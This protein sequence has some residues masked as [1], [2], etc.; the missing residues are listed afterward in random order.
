MLLGDKADYDCK[1][2]GTFDKGADNDGRH[3]VMAGLLRLAG[4]SLEGSL[5]DLTDTE[6]SGKGSQSRTDGLSECPQGQS[7]L[8]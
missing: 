2:T 4:S 6:C 5:S 1:Q 7:C 3:P 8:K